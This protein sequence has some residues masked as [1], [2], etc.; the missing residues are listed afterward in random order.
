M[1]QKGLNFTLSVSA[2]PQE[3]TVYIYFTH[4]IQNGVKIKRIPHR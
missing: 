1:T 3:N 2:L 4:D